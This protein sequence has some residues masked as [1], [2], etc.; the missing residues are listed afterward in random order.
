MV[1]WSSRRRYAAYRRQ[2]QQ[3]RSAGADDAADA[4]KR[5]ARSFGS[6]LWQFFGLLRGHGWEVGFAIATLTVAT[7]LKLAPPLATKVVIDYVLTDHPLPQ[8]WRRFGLPTD[9]FDLLYAVGAFVAVLS[10]V[11]TAIHLSGRWY[12]TT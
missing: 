2:L 3:R 10:L 1:S 11:A 7:L 5:A 12:A 6:L 8:A 9:R 4:R